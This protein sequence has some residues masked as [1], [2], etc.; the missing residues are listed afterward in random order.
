MFTHNRAGGISWLA[1]VALSCAMTIPS[2]AQDL[3]A[4]DDEAALYE[5][6][7][8]EGS[9]VWYS[10]GA[11]ETTKAMAASFEKQ[12]PGVRV[13][14]LRL[15]GASQYQRFME[16]SSANQ[17]IA[18]ILW[19]GDYPSM[20]SLVEDELVA[21]WT[22]PTADQFD[23]RYKLGTR[24]YAFNRVDSV[25]VYNENLVDDEEAALLEA[26]WR[27]ILDPRFKGRFAATTAKCG[28]CY[29]AINL[30]TD[31]AKA[32]IYPADFFEQ[33]GAQEPGIYSDFIA[34]VDRVVAGEND[35]AYWSFES[36][37]ATKRSQG[38]PV[39]WVYPK[40]TPS[41]PSTWMAVSEFAPHPAAARLFLNWMGSAAG[42]ES[43]QLDYFGTPTLNGVENIRSFASED[44]YRA[45]D[46]L[47]D[48]D[49]DRWIEHYETDMDRWIAAISR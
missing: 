3:P 35:F 45:P 8:A 21:D 49:F 2:I 19:I 44:W 34:M 10:G 37:A 16:E 42:A 43:I 47:Y 15:T 32:D 9:L 18:D 29:V 28:A 30:F 25:I 5:Q 24:A 26:D 27:N 6:A 17:F 1:A 33:V 36:I 14:V 39:R 46:E 23:D 38:A 11:L 12:Y 41:F 4:P 31:P 13:D 48:V 20:V 22:I 7:K 40:P